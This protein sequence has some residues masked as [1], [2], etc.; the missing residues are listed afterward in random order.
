MGT[1]AR[2]IWEGKPLVTTHWDGYPEGLGVVLLEAE[3][4]KEAI[5]VAKAF[6]INSVSKYAEKVMGLPAK[7]IDAYAE[8]FNPMNQTDVE[9]SY[10]YKNG[11]WF[12]K[13]V[14]YDYDKNEEIPSNLV[15]LKSKIPKK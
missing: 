4:P 5:K 7:K 14:E 8:Q 11:R 9:W 12:V 2:I 1:R 10:E 13:P 6:S 3:T 15:P